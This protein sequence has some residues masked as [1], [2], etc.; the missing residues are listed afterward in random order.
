MMS[1]EPSKAIK[2]S[3]PGHEVTQLTRI[4][5]DGTATNGRGRGA[6]KGKRRR[7][8]GREQAKA[9]KRRQGS[10]GPPQPAEDDEHSVDCL[11]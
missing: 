4:T 10:D 11:A 1:E 8:G 3:D 2:A 6:A 5:R 7:K 9:R